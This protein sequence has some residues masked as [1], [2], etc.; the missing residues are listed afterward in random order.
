MPL[1]FKQKE[2]I[3]TYA[4][5]PG[6][7]KPKGYAGPCAAPCERRDKGRASGDKKPT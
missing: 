1:S 6:W 2:R 5:L 4:P 3:A 7:A